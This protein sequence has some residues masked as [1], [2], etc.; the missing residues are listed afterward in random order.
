MLSST[1]FTWSTLEYFVPN[2]PT[3]M[4]NL[5]VMSVGESI[6][7]TG[8][9][10]AFFKVTPSIFSVFFSYQSLKIRNLQQNI[11]LAIYKLWFPCYHNS[12]RLIR[13]LLWYHGSKSL[14]FTPFDRIALGHRPIDTGLRLAICILKLLM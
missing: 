13:Q 9:R 12:R 4:E 2:V 5:I 7:F 11:N 14:R 10:T 3:F 8:T 6:F 1:N